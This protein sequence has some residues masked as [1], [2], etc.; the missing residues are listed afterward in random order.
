M[1][2]AECLA[3]ILNGKKGVVVSG[4]HGKTTTS[5]LCAHLMREGRMRPCHYVGAEIPVLGTNA[6]W[7]EDSEYLVA[8]GDESDGTLVNYIPEHSIVLNIEPEHLDHYKDL[9]EIKAVFDRLCSQTRGKIIYCRAHP[10]AE[11]VCAKYPNSVSYGWSDA[12][13]TATDVLERRGRTLFTVLKGK[14]ELGRVELGIPGRHNVLNSLA[15]IALATELGVDFPAVMRGLASFAGAKRRFE[16][17]YLSSSI[18]IVDDNGNSRHAPNCPFPPAEP[19]GSL[20]PAAP[21]HA[22]AASGG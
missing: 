10:G 1:R 17:K 16:T 6:H 2:R 4:T 5:A 21:L 9:D 13:Y 3:A 19:P 20:L 7:N 8:E 15:A 18:R 14:E 11:D 12:D 22:H